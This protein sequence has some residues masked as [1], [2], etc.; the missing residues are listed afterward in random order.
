MDFKKALRDLLHRFG[1]DIYNRRAP[2]IYSSD[3]FSTH[4]NHS[5]L[6]DPTFQACYARGVQANHGDDRHIHWRL[7]VALWV[8]QQAI[9]RPGAF[10]ECGVSHGFLSSA[11]MTKLDWNARERDYFLF[12]TFEGLDPAYVSAAE[13]AK[14]ERLSFYKDVRLETVEENFAEWQ[15]VHFVKGSIPET[16]SEVTIES[17][18]YLS[19]DMNCTL[20][21]LEALKYF[22]PKLS[23]GGFVLMD[24]YAYYGYEEQ[25][26]AYNDFSAEQ[27]VPILTLPTGQGMMMKP[28]T[29]AAESDSLDTTVS[30][31]VAALT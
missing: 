11:I 16:L 30:A 5:F 6:S 31:R 2:H 24:D 15:R 25:H 29:Q 9:Q 20:P 19:L 13:A 12:D 23:P 8:A 1:Y 3:M 10:V 21:E 28:L 26:A 4:H 7:H 14:D 22:W 27:G 18:A 17:V